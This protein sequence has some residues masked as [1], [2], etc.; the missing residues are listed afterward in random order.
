MSV[1]MPVQECQCGLQAKSAALPI[2]YIFWGSI[3]WTFVF[4]DVLTDLQFRYRNKIVNKN[5][6]VLFL[7][8]IS[9]VDR[10]T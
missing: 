4:E 10:V 7:G 1:K 2:I 6:S 3:F 8:P 9:P 5:V